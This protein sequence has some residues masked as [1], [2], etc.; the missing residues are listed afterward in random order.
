MH[1]NAETLAKGRHF[2]ATTLIPRYA[3]FRSP[4]PLKIGVLDDIRKLHPNVPAKVTRAALYLH[5]GAFKYLLLF[6]GSKIRVDL[7][8]ADAGQLDPLHAKSAALKLRDLDAKRRK[9]IAGPKAG[10][11]KR[12]AS[13]APSKASGRPILKLLKRAGPPAR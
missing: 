2:L 6:K 3:G 11:R 9:A 4:N 10:S 12:P 7:S 13:K 5:C 1:Y 8:G